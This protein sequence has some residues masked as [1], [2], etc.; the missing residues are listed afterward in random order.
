MLQRYWQ[1]TIFGFHVVLGS[2]EYEWRSGGGRST[3]AYAFQVHQGQSQSDTW[4]QCGTDI[5][6]GTLR[7]MF[8]STVY[9]PTPE[10]GGSFRP[11]DGNRNSEF[12]AYGMSK[13]CSSRV[14][15]THHGNFHHHEISTASL[16]RNLPQY[17][18][19]QRLPC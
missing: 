18:T 17:K 4:R 6:G 16:I 3:E 1:S 11:Q 15:P 5:F 14:V 12:C 13:V 9:T 8:I 10:I 2:S 7:H 19:W